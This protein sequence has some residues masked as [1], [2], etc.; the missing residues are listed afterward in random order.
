MWTRDPRLLRLLPIG[1]AL[2][3]GLAAGDVLAQWKWRD[4]KGQVHVSD[5]PPP[6]E[7]Q[8]KDV[9]QRPPAAPAR[10]AT[11]PAAATP[12]AADPEAPAAPTAEAAP[13]VDPELEARRKAAE[14]DKAARQRQDEQK[15]A[16]QRA[17][18]CERARAHLRQLDSGMRLARVNDKGERVVIDDK[19]RAAETQRTRQVIASDCR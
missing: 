3:L 18:N 10:A 2:A 14:Q 19:E 4:A 1:L 8:D 13:R 12:A 6:R 15:A 9:L 11:A 5:L 7:V 17:Q 16:A